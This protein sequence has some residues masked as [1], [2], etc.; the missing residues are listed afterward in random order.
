MHITLEADYA[1]R[2]VG[3]LV[4]AVY[5]RQRT[6]TPA[7]SAG[8]QAT[9]GSRLTTARLDAKTISERTH[10][11]LRFA[12]KILR[13]LVSAGIVRSFKGTQGGYELAKS[14]EVITLCT[15]I[16]CVEGPYRLSRC[17]ES[18]YICN[19]G[20]SGHCCFQDAFQKISDNVRLE[21]E[22]Y[23]FSNMYQNSR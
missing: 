12:L 1:V 20:A 5:G 4:E 6:P 13:K 11:T 7:H 22:S 19:R 3:C 21:L 18:E 15:V 16:E 8:D 14:P 17:L 10:V 23:T 2:I 9:P